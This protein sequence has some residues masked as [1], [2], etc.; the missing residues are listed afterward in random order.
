M[1][2]SCVV[3]DALASTFTYL[4]QHARQHACLSELATPEEKLSLEKPYRR[5]RVAGR[6]IHGLGARRG[7]LVAPSDQEMPCQVPSAQ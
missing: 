7:P 4:R 6:G 1:P 5:R 3:K 2:V